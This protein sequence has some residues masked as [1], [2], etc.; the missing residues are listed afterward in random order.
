MSFDVRRLDS[1]QRRGSPQFESFPQQFACFSQVSAFLDDS[2]LVD[3]IAKK[4]DIDH[5]RFHWQ[6]VSVVRG[7]DHRVLFVITEDAAQAM[8]VR[9][10]GSAS[11]GGD[12]FAP[13]RVG[14]VVHGHRPALLKQQ[15][16]QGRALLWRPEIQLCS[17]TPG[18][19]GVQ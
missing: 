18:V 7:D 17:I 10:E 19:D 15:Q 1:R 3:Q 9:A 16:D 6:C 2:C 8:D 12:R 4:S 5:F 11:R 13:Y 14:E